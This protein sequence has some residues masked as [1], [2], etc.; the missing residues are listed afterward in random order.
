[1]FNHTQARKRHLLHSRRL[2]DLVFVNFNLLLQERQQ[3]GNVGEVICLEKLS[4]LPPTVEPAEVD[5]EEEASG[6]HA[7][8]G[9]TDLCDP[10]DEEDEDE[11]DDDDE[12]WGA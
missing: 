10:S 12:D 7:P 11:E 5:E 4:L 8:V 3:R 1:M 2:N 9:V 6:S